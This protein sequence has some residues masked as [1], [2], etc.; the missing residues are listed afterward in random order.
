MATVCRGNVIVIIERFTD[1]QRLWLLRRSRG[2]RK[3]WT[4]ALLHQQPG[5]LIKFTD[6]GSF[7]RTCEAYQRWLD[8]W[9]FPFLN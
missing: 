4:L 1:P 9:S 6:A 7:V 3:P 5:T 2:A 8:P